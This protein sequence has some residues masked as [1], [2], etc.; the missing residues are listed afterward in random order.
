MEFTH[1]CPRV[2]SGHFL[3]DLHTEN[4]GMVKMKQLTRV[5][6]WWPELNPFAPEP[7]VTARAD[8]CP[9]YPL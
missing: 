3:A 6:F 7:P 1:H 9:F 8:P 2:I 5:Y 4:L